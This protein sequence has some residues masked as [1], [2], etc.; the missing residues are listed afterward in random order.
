MKIANLVNTITF[1]YKVIICRFEAPKVI[2][3]DQETHF[4]NEMIKDL[5]KRFQV[6]I[7]YHY[8]IIHKAMD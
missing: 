4:I 3:S 1:I 8:L 7:V 6:K 5:T 2:Q